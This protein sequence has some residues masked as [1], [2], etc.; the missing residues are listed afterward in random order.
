MKSLLQHPDLVTLHQSVAN[1]SMYNKILTLSDLKIMME[2]HVFAVWDF[3]SLLKRLQKEITCVEVPWVPS[4]YPK[5]LVRL[6]NEIVLGEESDLDQNGEAI[7][8]FTLYLNAMTE[9]GASSDKL[10]NFISDKD[11]SK[12]T[13][14]QKNFVEFNLSLASNGLVHEVAAAFFF[15]REK[16]IPDMFT[17]I[18]DDLEKNINTNNQNLFPNLKYYLIRHIEID[19]GEHS[20]QAEK[21]LA[22]LC[23]NDETK[24]NQA[25][26]AGVNSLKLRS[27]LWDEVEQSFI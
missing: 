24:W 4:C 26:L 2:T 9:I 18:L 13:I 6:I 8:H 11:Y 5:Q 17:S 16:L 22:V 3:M 27:A 20:H 19:G 21:C 7:D 25:R 15:G 14:A 1:H 10:L 23:G 12:I